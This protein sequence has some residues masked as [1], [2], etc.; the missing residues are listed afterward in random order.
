MRLYL[1]Y[2]TIQLKSAME[3]KTSFILTTIGQ[4]LV[5]FNG[6]LGILFMF[7][8]FHEIKGFRFSEILLCFSIVLMQFSLA[9]CFARGFDGFASLLSNGSFDRIMVRPRNVILQVLG[10][11]IE[12]TRLGRMV[13][14]I[15]MFVYGIAKSQVSWNVPR[16]LAVIF[17]ILGG[18]AVFFGLFLI[19]AA[20]CFFTLEGLEFMNV[21]TDGAREFGKYPISIYGN[22]VL[23]FCTFLV[24]YALI[25]YY[26]LLYILGKSDKSFYLVLPLIACLFLIPCFH[27]WKFGI[28]H[29]KSTGS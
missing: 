21:L 20:L 18:T 14:A 12:L 15:F 10:T 11:R 1:K 26:P 13:Q 7:Q 6:F 22:K 28:R 19:Y 23:L 16:I 24:P 5:S 25:Q 29:Y 4:F 17:M 9:E 8:R 3:Y 27:L 2:F